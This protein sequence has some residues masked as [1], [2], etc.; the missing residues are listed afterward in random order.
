MS[1]PQRRLCL[2]R[3]EGDSVELYQHGTKLGGV[4]LVQI[5]GDRVRLVFEFPDGIQIIRGE[6]ENKVIQGAKNG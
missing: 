1:Q 5:R 4:Q 2:T 3:H 6:V